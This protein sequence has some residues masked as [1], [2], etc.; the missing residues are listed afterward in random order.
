MPILETIHTINLFEVALA[1][2]RNYKKND[3]CALNLLA[4]FDIL[5]VKDK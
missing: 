3:E 4:C 1:N 5:G 2:K